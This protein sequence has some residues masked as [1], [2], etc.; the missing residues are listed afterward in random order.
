M[1]DDFQYDVFLS[2]SS[3]DKAVVRDVARRLRAYGLRVWL[4]EDEIKPGDHIQRKV[5]EGLE[6]SR[7]LV[8]C[9][10]ANALGSDWA[11]LEAGTLS[12]SQAPALERPVCE[13]PASH[14]F[15][16]RASE[17]MGT[18]AGAWEPGEDPFHKPAACGCGGGGAV[19]RVWLAFTGKTR[20]RD[21]PPTSAGGAEACWRSA[22]LA[23]A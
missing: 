19:T 9:M 6:H 5:E 1:A 23:A 21:A 18:Q 11:K 20:G 22:A 14:L 10:S 7:V 3:K 8:L 17:I 15:R 13:A 12:R 16:S 4:D 2:H